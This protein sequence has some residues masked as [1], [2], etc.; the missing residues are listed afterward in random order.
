MDTKHLGYYFNFNEGSAPEPIPGGDI[1]N[2]L[3]QTGD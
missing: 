1:F 2:A 3:T